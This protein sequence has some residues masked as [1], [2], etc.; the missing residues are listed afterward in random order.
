MVDITKEAGEG[1]TIKMIKISVFVRTLGLLCNGYAACFRVGMANR[2]ETK[3][4]ISLCV[5]TKSHII[6]MGTHEHHP[7]CC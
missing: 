4:H 6:H 3:R 2:S 7:I 5:N 1:L